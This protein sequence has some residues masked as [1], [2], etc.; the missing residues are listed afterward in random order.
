MF[1]IPQGE[2]FFFKGGTIGCLLLHGFT[3][4]P[5][6]MRP[7]G[8]HLSDNGFTTLGIRLFA[9]STKPTDMTRA[10]WQDWIADIDGGWHLLNSMTDKIFILGLSMGGALSLVYASHRPVAGVVAMSTPHHMPRDPRLPFIK[11]IS[12]FKPTID[13]GEPD[14]FDLEALS[15]RVCYP[16]DPTRAYH[17]VH[18]LLKTLQDRLP[19][20]TTP[21][22]LI[23]SK[24]DQTIKTQDKHM[25][26]IFNALGSRHKET[27]L[28]ENSGHVIT[29]DLERYTVFELCTNFIK[30]LSN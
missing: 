27:K 13:K 17:E 20:I 29:R 12:Y 7:L 3:G 24:N 16:S 6:E 2:P 1:L 21:C 26:S 10:R 22:L 19:Y 9:H 25:E 4:T 14:W 18:L 30:N 23:N 5:D 8:K 11:L 15:Q 28:I